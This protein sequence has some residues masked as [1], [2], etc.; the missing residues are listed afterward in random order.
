MTIRAM[1]MRK[2]PSLE[3][4]EPEQPEQE[5]VCGLLK[6]WIEA[7]S[8]MIVQYIFGCIHCMPK[9]IALRSILCLCLAGSG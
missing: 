1:A 5:D 6:E 4:D 7:D 8:P 2:G 3:P 9:A